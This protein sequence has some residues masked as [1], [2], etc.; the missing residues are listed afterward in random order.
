LAIIGIVVSMI[1]DMVGLPIIKI[2]VEKEDE[3]D[4]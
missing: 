2:K 3:K 1:R 4:D